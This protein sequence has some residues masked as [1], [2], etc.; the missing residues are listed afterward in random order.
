MLNAIRP[1]A[2]LLAAVVLVSCGDDSGEDE[3][4]GDRQPTAAALLRG[5]PTDFD[6][7]PLPENAEERLLRQLAPG[8][9]VD[10][11]SSSEMRQVVDDGTPI[12]AAM[13]LVG[14]R[15]L[16]EDD[17]LRGF[18]R[19]AGLAR[20]ISLAGK[21][22]RIV[23]VQGLTMIIDVSGKAMVIVAATTE[24]DARRLGRR[25]LLD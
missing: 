1:A 14:E 16:G 12:G 20:T 3:G 21:Q 19:R 18:E 22:A 5:L 6:Y 2:A 25:V 17:V 23:T 13:A 11:L 15:E 24:A 9:V 4:S 8:W 10:Q 7:R